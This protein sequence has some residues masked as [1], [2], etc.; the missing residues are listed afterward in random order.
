MTRD[1]DVMPLVGSLRALTRTYHMPLCRRRSLVQDSRRAHQHSQSEGPCAWGI[2]SYSQLARA[3]TSADK[4]VIRFFRRIV[5][6]PPI[7]I[8]TLRCLSSLLRVNN[9]KKPL[10]LTV[11][12]LHATTV[13]H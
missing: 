10:Q 8:R 2:T 11:L 9:D 4:P 3:R 6:R 1:E 13:C 12:V 5:N 7:Q